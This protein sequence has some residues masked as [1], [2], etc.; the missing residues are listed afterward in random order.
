MECC[1]FTGHR[2]IESE[3]ASA[4]EKLIDRAVEYAYGKGCRKFLCGGALGFDT[5]AAL[6][7]L[8]LKARYP[9]IKLH[10]Y[11]P[12]RDQDKFWN[13]DEKE[14]YRVILQHADDVLYTTEHYTDGCMLKRNREMIDG[15]GICIA[16]YQHQGAGGTG[17]SYRYALRTGVTVINLATAS[18][19]SG[20]IRE[21]TTS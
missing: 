11:L 10:L 19:E 18:A 15:C 6:K 12:C 5:M 4:L 7:V 14:L 1:S 3:K 8:E 17:Y 13:A 21:D 20:Q 16:Y 9:Q 2:V